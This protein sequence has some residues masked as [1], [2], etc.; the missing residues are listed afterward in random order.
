MITK[1]SD[2]KHGTLLYVT[3]YSL[4]V[5]TSLSLTGCATTKG[6]FSSWSFFGSG[7]EEKEEV[8]EPAATLVVGAMD[9]Y[10]VGKYNTALGFFQKIKDRYPFS[11]QALLAELKSA[12][13][14]YYNEDYEK[15]K[16]LY[17]EFEEQHP[18]NEAVPYI[19]FQIGMCDFSR[20]DQLDRDPSGAQD[21]IKSFSR[22]LRAYPD[23]PY[24]N[25]AKSRIKTARN[26]IVNHEYMVAVFYVRTKKYKQAQH[27]L[28]YLIAMYPDA[29]VI[30]QAKKLQAR[31]EAGDP[32]KWGLDKWLPSWS[33]PDWSL[34]D[35]GIGK[36]TADTQE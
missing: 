25:E 10:R 4:L 17:K 24:T 5:A 19:M 15:A 21:S 27:R 8:V 26:F 31:L 36:K 2:N 13:C 23:S 22:L 35:I 1:K 34:E 16:M 30:P 3:I 14:E 9:A 11:P 12:D 7:E 18:T 32:P 28:K 29:F 20:T 33:M 6:M